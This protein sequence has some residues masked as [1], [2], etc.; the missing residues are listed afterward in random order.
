MHVLLHGAAGDLRHG[1]ARRQN[2]AYLAY[3]VPLPSL[4]N[5][6]DTFLS[7]IA[8][9]VVTGNLVACYSISVQDNVWKLI[10]D[11]SASLTLYVT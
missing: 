3:Y 2:M 4:P 5:S 8:W 11:K 9:F 7:S 6:F 10:H 1:T